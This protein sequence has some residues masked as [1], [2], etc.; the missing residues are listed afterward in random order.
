LK[1]ARWPGSIG[2]NRTRG[3]L[4]SLIFVK[5]VIMQNEG[6]KQHDMYKAYTETQINEK[7]EIYL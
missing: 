2:D 4:E 7:L 5:R 3:D 6:K 1:F